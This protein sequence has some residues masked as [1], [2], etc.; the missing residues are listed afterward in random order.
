MRMNAVFWWAE[1]TIIRMVVMLTLR[2]K[3]INRHIEPDFTSIGLSSLAKNLTRL[4]RLR[5]RGWIFPIWRFIDVFDAGS[6]SLPWISLCNSCQSLYFAETFISTFLSSEVSSHKCGRSTRVCNTLFG[7]FE[8]VSPSKGGK[9]FRITGYQVS[10][11]H[12]HLRKKQTQS[13]HRI[14]LSFG[15]LTLVSS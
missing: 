15:H 7:S 3:Y 2:F 14:H 1:L 9:L 8:Y 4:E 10:N 12:R 6:V 5:G 13:P 11:T